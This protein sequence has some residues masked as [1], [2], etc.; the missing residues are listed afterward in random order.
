[1]RCGKKEPIKRA[2]NGF[3]LIELVLVM[4]IIG[5]VAAIALPRF[6]QANAR[7]QLEAAAN[8]V[9]NDLERARHEARASSNAVAISFSTSDNSYSYAS[10]VGT[11]FEMQLDESPYQVELSKALFNGSS[12]VAFNGYGMPSSNGPVTL[13]SNA[14]TVKV[15][16]DATGRV[17]R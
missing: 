7:Q 14:G 10:A 12:N 16:L 6:A 9:V 17:S 4:F 1:M 5:I 13:K 2:A 11:T 8:R 15:T 3:S